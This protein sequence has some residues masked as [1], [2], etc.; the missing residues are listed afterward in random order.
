MMQLTGV[1]PAVRNM[2]DFEKILESDFPIVILLE[3]RIAQLGQLVK[4]IRNK[5]KKVF[6]HVDLIN[7]LKVDQYGMEYLIRDIKIDGVIST[8]ANVISMAKKNNII[9]IQRLFAIDSSA[10]DKNLELVTKTQPD[11]IEVLPGIVPSIIIDI[12]DKTGIPVIAGGLIKSKEDIDTALN[13]GAK[14]ITTSRS[15]LWKY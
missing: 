12:V 13:S 11:Y 15:N 2:K 9:A 3:T 6:V 1:L 14:A 10:I 7:G 8:R 4:L 5:K